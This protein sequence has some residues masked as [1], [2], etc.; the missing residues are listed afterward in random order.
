MKKSLLI[1]SEHYL[2]DKC[3]TLTSLAKKVVFFTGAGM[4]AES[5]IKTF[6]G[7]GGFWNGIVG[8]IG[9][10][11]FGT[12]YGWN[13]TSRLAYKAYKMYF[14]DEISKAKPNKGH[15]A[16][17][18]LSKLVPELKIITQNV[19]G[20]HQLGG[21]KDENVY[22][23]HGTVKK[24]CCI[25]NK[26]AYE[27]KDNNN[28]PDWSPICKVKG[29]GS[30]I[31][32]KVTLFMECLPFGTMIKSEN[33]IKEMTVNDVMFVIGSSLQVHPAADLPFQAYNKGIKIIE[34]NLEKT[35]LSKLKGVTFLE[36]KS[37]EILSKIVKKVKDL[38]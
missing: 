19:D 16:I 3:I 29:C 35:N 34:I 33:Y 11:F 14:W 37:G 25:E 30:Y 2:L 24:Y 26:H 36:G 10:G 12:P 13:Y 9:L 38:K 32:P 20:L 22:E 27:M 8:K 17:G 23:L 6:R 5:G 7:G 21:I 18:E 15:M 4:S 28:I 31:R 1:Q